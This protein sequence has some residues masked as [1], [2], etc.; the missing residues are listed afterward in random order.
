MLQPSLT[1]LIKLGSIAVHAD[2]LTENEGHAAHAFDMVALRQLIV[3]P[4]VSR[5]VRDMGALLPLK[6][7][8]RHG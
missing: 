1:L 5:W 6:R 7:S 4:E 8:T 3:D 2:E